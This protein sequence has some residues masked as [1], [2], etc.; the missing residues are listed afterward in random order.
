MKRGC[1]FRKQHGGAVA[2]TGASQQEGQGFNSSLDLSVFLMF[3][4]WLRRQFSPGAPASSPQS[5]DMRTR[6]AGYSKIS[7]G[8]IACL[9]LMIKSEFPSSLPATSSETSTWSHNVY[10]GKLEERFDKPENARPLYQVKAVH[11]SI[12]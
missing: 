8:V 5:K 9:S 2:D 4:L 7:R 12:Y 11:Y 10:V 6:L 3:F 1:P